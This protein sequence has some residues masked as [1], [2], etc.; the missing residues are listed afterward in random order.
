MSRDMIFPL[1]PYCRKR[2]HEIFVWK[3]L[4]LEWFRNSIRQSFECVDEANHRRISFIGNRVMYD[5]P[6]ARQLRRRKRKIGWNEKR[7]SVLAMTC[8]H[9]L[10][11]ECMACPMRSNRIY[12][13]FK[14]RPYMH[15]IHSQTNFFWCHRRHHVEWFNWNMCRHS[16]QMCVQY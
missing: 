4:F 10:A 5:S 8:T 11:A 9:P 16:V 15:K 1:S 7:K 14:R 6:T 12:N 2:R 3:L 13:L